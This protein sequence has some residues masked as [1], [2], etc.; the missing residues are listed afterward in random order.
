MTFV[1]FILDQGSFEVFT[2][3]AG[4]EAVVAELEAVPRSNANKLATAGTQ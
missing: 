2:A 1:V 3:V 4:L